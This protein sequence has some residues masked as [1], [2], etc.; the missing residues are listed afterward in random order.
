MKKVLLTILIIAGMALVAE[1]VRDGH[2]FFAA[3]S[4]DPALKIIVVEPGSFGKTSEML[5]KEGLLKDPRRFYLIAR[6]LRASSNVKVGEYEVRM[7]M[8]PYELLGVLTSGKSVLHAV[9][10]PE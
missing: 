1:V 4:T 9:H 2:F 3:N 10:I 5:F 8:S 7:N 6:L